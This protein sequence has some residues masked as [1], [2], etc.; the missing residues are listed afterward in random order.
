MITLFKRF[1]GKE[2]ISSFDFLKNYLDVVEKDMKFMDGKMFKSDVYACEYSLAILLIEYFSTEEKLD[3]KLSLI[4]GLMSNDNQKKLSF[5]CNLIV[6]RIHYFTKCAYNY[7]LVADT[8]K[9]NDVIDKFRKYGNE[10]RELELDLRQYAILAGYTEFISNVTDNKRLK[11]LLG[12]QIM[13]SDWLDQRRVDHSLMQ[14]T[15][16][17]YDVAKVFC[18]KFRVQTAQDALNKFMQQRGRNSF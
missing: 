18:E 17:C 7:I 1:I 11:I 5:N 8:S 6:D 12:S 10:A 3:S 14:Y 15:K 13:M 9:A 16:E 2:D 4:Y